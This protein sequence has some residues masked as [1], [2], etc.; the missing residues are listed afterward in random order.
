MAGTRRRSG[1][2]RALGALPQQPRLLEFRTIPDRLERFA[3]LVRKTT[4]LKRK[5]N[6]EKKIA[7][8]YYGSIGKEAATGGLGVSES[9][10]NV[11]KRLQKAGY[12]TG[13]SPKRRNS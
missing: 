11:L 1:P 5:P 8:I 12:T 3:E 10:L 6:S 2:L 7:I 4:D 9:I 13:R